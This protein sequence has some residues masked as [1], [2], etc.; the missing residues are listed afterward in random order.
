MSSLPVS[1]LCV[2]AFL[3]EGLVEQY[4]PHPLDLSTLFEF[5]K[6]FEEDDDQYGARKMS[7]LLGNP[8][9]NNGGMLES[10]SMS[11]SMTTPMRF[12]K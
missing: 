1:F 12:T 8:E 9:N 11:I 5:L 4:V 10:T 6:L 3:E 2:Q 7:F